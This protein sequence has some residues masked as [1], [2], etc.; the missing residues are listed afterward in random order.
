M[1]LVK[2]YKFFLRPIFIS[3]YNYQRRKEVCTIKKGGLSIK[4]FDL[5]D[6]R[7]IFIFMLSFGLFIPKYK[8]KPSELL[9]KD[10]LRDIF[11]S[12]TNFLSVL[13]ILEKVVL[14]WWTN[15]EDY[16]KLVLTLHQSVFSI[17]GSNCFSYSETEYLLPHLNTF[18]FHFKVHFNS[19]KVEQN[20]FLIEAFQF[21]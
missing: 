9:T 20:K 1:H 6:T 11:F 14:L 5:I 2:Y 21:L 15:M 19:S 3:R 8:Y 13:R 16:E 10:K 4:P 7:F 17:Q 18:T 12:M